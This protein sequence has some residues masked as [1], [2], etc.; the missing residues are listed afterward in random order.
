VENTMPTTTQ[1]KYLDPE[2]LH[3]LKNLSLAARLVVEGF[4]AG[5]HKSPHKGF[6]I[7]FAEHREYTPGIDP[8]HIDWRVFGRRDKLYVKQYEEETSL[9]C[10]LLLDK[11]ASMGYRSD[12]AKLTKLEYASYLTASLAYLMAFQHDTVG[13]ITYDTGV[14]DRIP[15]RQG[16][17]HL[18]VLLEKLEDTQPGGET[19]LS[20]TFHQLAENIK[21]RALVVVIS[22]LFDDAEKLVGAL[23]HFRHKKHEVIVLHA[24]DPAE[25]TFPFDDV[26]RIEDMENNREVISDPRAFRKSY[27]EELA[28]FLDTIRGGCQGCQIDYALAQTDQRFDLFLGTYLARRQA[29]HV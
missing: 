15:P 2:G 12:D 17:A 22:D 28:K 29:M 25:V 10:Y 27:L 8:K 14:R 20:D 4:F 11:S 1:Y 13:L 9:R 21:R 24:L 18:R 23:K 16:P 6:S 5:M 3:R 26:T 7:E 19:S